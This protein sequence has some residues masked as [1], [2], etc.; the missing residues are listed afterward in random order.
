MGRNA[1]RVVLSLLTFILES[2][3]E[4]FAQEGGGEVV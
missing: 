4:G 1:S 2:A 3:G